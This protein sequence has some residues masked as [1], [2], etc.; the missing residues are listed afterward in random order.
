MQEQLLAELLAANE[1]LLEALR[2]Y[3]DLERLANE[4]RVEERSRREVT[5]KGAVSSR[6]VA[7]VVY[8][9]AE[10]HLGSQVDAVVHGHSSSAITHDD[11]SRPPSPSS[12]SGQ[13][14]S[15]SSV[16]PP[17]PR[18]PPN[19]ETAS[20]AQAALAQSLAPPPPAPHGPRSPAQLSIP[21][22]PPSPVVPRQHSRS[23]S[24]QSRENGNVFKLGRANSDSG[25][26][27][28][29]NS[30]INAYDQPSAKA[31]GKRKVVDDVEREIVFSLNTV[32][33]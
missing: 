16:T 14:D 23:S 5:T 32:L 33:H 28:D 31:L 22:R 1:A 29:D 25:P 9:I 19:L 18:F 24:V 4:R 27:D 8:C 26:N 11:S 7:Y 30:H 12:S 13:S 15:V 21:S 6:N 20:I 3:D 2:V 17:G 10:L